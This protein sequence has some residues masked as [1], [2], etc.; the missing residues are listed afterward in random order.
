MSNQR[1]S[2]IEPDQRKSYWLAGD[3]IRFLISGDQTGGAY[4]LGEVEIAPGGGPPPH[5]H[6]REDELFYVIDGQ[7]QFILDQSTFT[8]GGGFAAL[9]PRGVTHTFKNVG[10]APA[11]VLALAFPGGFDRFAVDAGQ[12]WSGARAPTNADIEK[13]LAMCPKYGIEMRPQ[14]KPAS[15]VPAP[16]SNQE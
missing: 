15:T 4:A 1:C 5:V 12:P 10:P 8:A 2:V 6:T 7:I 11:R 9:L 3:R 16:V 14:W 13:L